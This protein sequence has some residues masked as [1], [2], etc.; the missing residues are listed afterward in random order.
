MVGEAPGHNEEREGEPFIGA[1]GQL[2]NRSLLGAGIKRQDVMVTNACKCR[3]PNNRTPT[4]KELKACS[5]HTDRELTP[6]KYVLILGAAALKQQLGGQASINKLRGRVFEKDGR[7]FLPTYHPA[8]IMRDARAQPAFD[9]DLRTF[10]RLVTTG[11]VPTEEGLNTRIIT[12]SDQ[13]RDQLLPD[14]SSAGLV[15]LDLETSGIYA[16]APGAHVVSLG[17]GTRTTQ[18]VLPINHHEMSPQ[19]K[20]SFAN[21]AKLIYYVRAIARVLRD[22][23][24]V[25]QFSKFDAV[26]LKLHFDIDVTFDYDIGLAHYQ[27]NENSLHDLEFL[28]Q[29]YY[30]APAYDVSS[31]VKNGNE[32][33]LH[34]HAEYLSKDLYYTRKLRFDVDKT[35][36]DNSSRRLYENITLP[37]SRMYRDVELTGVTI[38]VPRMEEVEKHLNREVAKAE[39]AFQRWGPNVNLA[40]PQQLVKLL[41]GKLK[42]KPLDVTKTGQPSTNASVLK[43]IDHPCV[44]SILQHRRATKLLGTFIEGWKPYLVDGRLHPSFKIHGTVTGRPSC[45]NPNF[46]QTDRDPIIRS[47]VIAPDGWQLVEFD[48]SQAEL[49]IV[50]E[51]SRDPTMLK[52]FMEGGDIHR[53]TAS[54]VLGIPPEDIDDEQRYIAKSLNFGLIYAM[55]E[56]RLMQY[57]RDEYGVT[58]TRQEAHRFRTRFFQLYSKLLPWHERQRLFARQNGYVR[59][60][61]GRIRRLPIAMQ[62]FDSPERGEAERQAINSPVQSFV[63]DMNLMIALQASREFSTDYFRLC[64]TVHDSG[65]AIVRTDMVPTVG[66]RLLTIMKRPDLMDEWNIRLKV[67][68]VGEV[69]VGAWSKGIKLEKWVANAA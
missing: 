23:Q 51:L 66:N 20:R 24:V 49:R 31:D 65:M 50:A 1:A 52:I 15:S 33:S 25:G 57:C 36:S 42:I 34:E 47:L 39:K 11:G 58:L 12:S 4:M 62:P 61:C 46:Q 35:L 41:F 48:L 63:S 6:A 30:S 67:P 10:A 27:A 18:W 21:Q 26:W 8:Y 13:I 40:S 55:Y 45:E 60:L 53:H 44:A 19:L 37:A 54:V 17:L 29:I 22:C 14:I 2:L 69:K 9:A 7:Y 28:A 43:R 3:P 38:D 5:V 64:A 59:N 56:K 32:G 16:W 68:M